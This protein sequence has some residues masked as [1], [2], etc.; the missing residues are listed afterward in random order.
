MVVKDS[1]SINYVCYV[2][3]ELHK[4]EFLCCS[5]I[6]TEPTSFHV[7]RVPVTTARRIFELR[8]KAMASRYGGKR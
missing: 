2:M 1:H 3:E 6:D 4:G 5:L 8:V 7:M